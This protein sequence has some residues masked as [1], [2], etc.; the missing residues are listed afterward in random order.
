MRVALLYLA[1]GANPGGITKEILNAIYKQT[2]GFLF[3]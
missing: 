2:E 3:D 1:L